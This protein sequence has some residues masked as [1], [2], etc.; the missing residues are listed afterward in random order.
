MHCTVS[1]YSALNVTILYVTYGT[2]QHYAQLHRD[3]AAA[4]REKMTSVN[5]PKRRLGANFEKIQIGWATK[6]V[7]TIS[8]QKKTQRGFKI[9]HFS[10]N[11]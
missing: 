2:G 1:H 4:M 3:A 9:L 11:L 5:L 6:K 10:L 8:G 7:L